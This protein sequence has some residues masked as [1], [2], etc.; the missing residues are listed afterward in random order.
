MSTRVTNLRR[1]M[2]KEPRQA[3]SRA[4]VDIII[5]AGARI[6]SDHG[7]AHLT[8]NKVADMAGVSIGSLYQ[9]FPDKL[10]LTEAI[11]R[12]HLE[13]CLAVVR[14]SGKERKPFKQ[15]AEE[16]VHDMLAAHSVH[17]GLHRVL[18]DEAPSYESLAP[19]DSFEAEYLSHYKKIVGVY[20]QRKS[21]S[22]KYTTALLT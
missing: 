1:P 12:R 11:R 18:L 8:T 15:F 21:N 13:D 19:P 2:R 4:T 3:R 17:P 9:Y 6:L 10:S 7:W 14:R 16:L 20:Q 22:R 5:D